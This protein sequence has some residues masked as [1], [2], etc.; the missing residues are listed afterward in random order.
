ML[1][2]KL[3]IEGVGESSLTVSLFAAHAADA[4]FYG[5]SEGGSDSDADRSDIDDVF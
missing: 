4:A 2:A 5:D 3:P 1:Q